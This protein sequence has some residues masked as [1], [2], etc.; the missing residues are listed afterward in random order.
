MGVARDRGVHRRLTLI[1]AAG[2]VA[3][4]C[5]AVAL[6][7]VEPAGTIAYQDFNHDYTGGTLFRLGRLSSLYDVSAQA[8]TVR[9]VLGFL[10]S[11]YQ[12]YSMLPTAAALLAPL[13]VLPYQTA[14][15]VYGAINIVLLVLAAVTVVSTLRPSRRAERLAILAV[16]GAGGF[17]Y[18]LLWGQ[19]DALSALL[20]ALTWRDL[21]NGREA[22]AGVW[23]A[24]AG[25]L[26]KPHLLLGTAVLVLAWGRRRLLLSAAATAAALAVADLLLVGTSGVAAWL[27]VGTAYNPA[28][29]TVRMIGV[30][31][32]TATIAGQGTSATVAGAVVGLV[33]LAVCAVLGRRLAAHPEELD[34][35][36]A[37]S[38][39]LSLYG[40]PHS[41]DYNLVLLGPAMTWMVCVLWRRAATT[42]ASRTDRATLLL[43]GL[44]WG[45]GALAF[46]EQVVFRS[47]LAFR[48]SP[49]LLLGLAVLLIRLAAAPRATPDRTAL[50]TP[51]TGR[52]VP[53]GEP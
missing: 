30:G 39:A 10:P 31:S 6:W 3:F 1:L 28:Y 34:G 38:I 46:A 36:L 51:E 12:P 8:E 27:H 25:G 18:M 13:S 9:G 49:F 15:R 22:R 50:S 24:L 11:D 52:K 33:C 43:L 45:M 47:H 17:L 44:W 23:L 35:L 4:L 16:F 29:G 19:W 40:S 2:I 32:L 7:I 53:V 20:L 21:R 42:G 5:V 37:A 14:F 41:F 48:L 26:G